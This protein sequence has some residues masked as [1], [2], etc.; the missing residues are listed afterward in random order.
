L[1]KII[2]QGHTFYPL[3]FLSKEAA[4]DLDVPPD[5]FHEALERLRQKDWIKCVEVSTGERGVY[6]TRIFVAEKSIAEDLKRIQK[7][8]SVLV[9]IS[10]EQNIKEIE[11]VNRI[12]F[13]EG[14]FRAFDAALQEKLLVI[15]GGP[16]TGKTTLIKGIVQAFNRYGAQ[17]LLAA[18]TGRAAKRLSQSAEMTAKTI[19]R[20]LEYNPAANS[21]GR[22]KGN[23]LE[24]DL[25]IIDEASM[26]DILLLFHLLQAVGPKTSVIFVGDA[27]QLP[28]VGPGNVLR[29]MIASGRIPVV[30][31]RHIFR[32]K[33]GSEIILNAHCINQG[34]MIR[35]SRGKPDARH[36]FFIKKKEPEAIKEV[37]EE[38]VRKR[39]PKKFG[40]NSYSDIQVITPMHKGIVGVEKLNETLQSICNPQ[41]DGIARR[42]FVLKKGDKVMQIVNNY[43]K[44]V[45]NGDIG[46]IDRIDREGGFIVVDFDGRKVV[47]DFI[48]L[49]ELV[50][51]YAISVHKSQGSEYRCVIMPVT[52]QHFI[53]L[54]RNLLYTAVTRGKE[55]VILVGD[56]EALQYAIGN[57]R[58]ARRYTDLQGRIIASFDY[59]GETET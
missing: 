45:F 14:Q 10:R 19:H 39:I 28:S 46:F 22:H 7:G 51:A 21:F 36:F 24:C 12:V 30:S 42:S 33:K 34:R 2:D 40:L 37:I 11:A 58:M 18:P 25:V 4:R 27:D 26:V 54:Q 20:L 48:D 43:D 55:L 41:T 35:M 13:S 53:M 16:G 57:D 56:E 47:Y 31:L 15:T 3:E 23:P 59:T 38:L 1:T 32:Q 8:E 5:I 49:D 29:D 52:H 44:D 50:L 17:V 6:L 9:N